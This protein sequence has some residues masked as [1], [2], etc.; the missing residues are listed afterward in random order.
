MQKIAEILAT[1]D[2]IRS[3][4]LVDSNSAWIAERLEETGIRVTRHACVGDEL[5]RLVAEFL[6]IGRRADLAVVTGG[7]GPTSD[8]LTAQAAAGAVGRP[9][10]LFPEALAAIEAFF[11]RKNRSMPASNTKQAMLPEGAEI[12]ENPVGTAPG[13]SL[14]IEGCL[15]FFLPGVPREMQIM[16]RESVLPAV[17]R[18]LGPQPGVMKTR[19][20]SSF[21]LTESRAADALAGFEDRFP[22]IKLGFR[23][24]FP[25]IQVKLYLHGERM[26]DIENLE[27]EA[28]PWLKQR[29]GE[30]LI[31][32]TGET[33][34]MVV[35]RLLSREGATVA[36]AESCTGGL[37][38]HWLTSHPGSSAYFLL[39][40]VTYADTAKHRVLG[41]S[42]DTLATLGAV[43]E[44]T[45]LEM[46][47]G[48]R[49]LAAADYGL[50]I[51]GVAGPGGGS[52][53]K[54]VGCVCFGLAGPDISLATTRQFHF[55]NRHQNQSMAAAYSLDLLRRQLLKTHS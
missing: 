29:I 11:Q 23:A 21:G 20:L 51:T 49:D 14:E 5:P 7:L 9:T 30:S 33:L 22:S 1:G 43:S 15:F 8:D 40:A 31:S 47:R 19:T 34:P 17:R 54:P 45:A 35:G 41:V 12:I 2:E 39:A 38:A 52:P 32:E 4:A 50:S 6:E 24:L 44:A 55:E 18:F 37:A 25:E 36:L 46:A 28:V 16:C 13:F 27:L 48:V 42:E 53:E 26:A 10:R 3:G